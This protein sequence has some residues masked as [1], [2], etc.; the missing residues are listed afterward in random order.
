MKHLNSLLISLVY[1]LVSSGAIVNL[2]YC[3]GELEGV[4]VNIETQSCCCGAV[5]LSSSCCEFEELILD[6]D[7]D[8]NIAPASNSL[9]KL[10]SQVVLSS[11]AR[12]FF[13]NPEI[14]EKP[15][16]NE[17]LTPPKSE[18]IWLMNCTFTFYG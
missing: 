3:G 4:H 8:E 13:G 17:M 2:H 7:I 5:N 10:I 14:E 11:S 16:A 6:I 15:S 12:D 1:L 9:V 18:P